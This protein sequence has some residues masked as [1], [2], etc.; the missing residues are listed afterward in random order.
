MKLLQILSK[1]L[2]HSRFYYLCQVTKFE[3]TN[4]EYQSDSISDF[5]KIILKT[6]KL[7]SIGHC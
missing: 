4:S 6:K 5:P 1:E 2:I 7:L 3:Y